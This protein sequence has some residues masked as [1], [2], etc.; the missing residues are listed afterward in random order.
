VI[1]PE[2]PTRPVDE[3]PF[4]KSSWSQGDSNCVEVALV[5]GAAVVRDTKARHLG[6]VVLPAAGW[7]GLLAAVKAGRVIP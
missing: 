2:H 7:N 6:A 3:L 1:I 4:R 5:A